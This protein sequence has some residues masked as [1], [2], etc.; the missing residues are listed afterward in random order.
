MRSSLFARNAYLK[1]S[2][3]S[4][5][6]GTS[7]SLTP[8]PPFCPFLLLSLFL[9]LSSFLFSHFRAHPCAYSYSSDVPKHHA[10]CVHFIV[11]SSVHIATNRIQMLLLCS[12]SRT[13]LS[14]FY[15]RNCSLG[16][17]YEYK[18]YG[19][20]WHFYSMYTNVMSN[21]WKNSI[22]ACTVNH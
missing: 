8:P 1:F 9:S 5:N 19:R 7:S 20:A 18:L 4:N 13:I 16:L 11:H 10:P 22:D 12:Q 6:S 14:G 17:R 15:K 3:F 2:I 21:F